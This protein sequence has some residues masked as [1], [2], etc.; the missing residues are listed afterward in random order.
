MVLKTFWAGGDKK[1]TTDRL[2]HFRI[3]LCHLMACFMNHQMNTEDRDY[4]A[5]AG[6]PNAKPPVGS[7]PQKESIVA[8]IPTDEDVEEQK[9]LVI[10][11]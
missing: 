10:Q 1:D 7:I 3:K 4:L 6:Y 11:C 8:T 9:C 2:L 5:I